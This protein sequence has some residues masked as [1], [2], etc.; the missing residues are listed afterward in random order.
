M[1]LWAQSMKLKCFMTGRQQAMTVCNC[2]AAASMVVRQR[3]LRSGICAMELRSLLLPQA[4]LR[5]AP[6]CSKHAQ[7]S[8]LGFSMIK[9]P[10]MQIS[11]QILGCCLTTLCKEEVAGAGQ[12]RWASGRKRKLPFAQN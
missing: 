10:C 5:D 9:A 3:G 6:Y 4:C 1:L 8:L 11:L 12:R 7:S 2:A